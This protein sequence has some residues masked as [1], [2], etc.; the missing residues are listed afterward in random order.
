MQ[1]VLDN[2]KLFL[3]IEMKSNKVKNIIMKLFSINPWF[4]LLML[5]ISA[6]LAVVCFMSNTR[7]MNYTLPSYDRLQYVEGTVESFNRGS[8]RGNI[9]FELTLN[10]NEVYYL[11]QYIIYYADVPQTV[12]KGTN[13]KMLI[14]SDYRN[15][16]PNQIYELEI[17]Q[18]KS[19]LYEE[20]CDVLIS[21]YKEGLKSGERMFLGSFIICAYVCISLA[22]QLLNKH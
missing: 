18:N 4:L 12:E 20:C 11:N 21:Y 22:V 1:E 7:M 13:V 19:L 2:I 15:G 8:G 10:N 3:G 16:F 6:V 17:N 5:F 14:D 9:L